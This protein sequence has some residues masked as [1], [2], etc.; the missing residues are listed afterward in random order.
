[1]ETKSR[2]FV[3]FDSSR[4]SGLQSCQAVGLLA[5]DRTY[6]DLLSLQR[7]VSDT[8]PPLDELELMARM[9]ERRVL[10]PRRNDKATNDDV[11]SPRR[12]MDDSGNGIRLMVCL[13]AQNWCWHVVAPQS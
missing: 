5:C 8:K 13:V 4:V 9:G 1:M 7:L 11:E 2:R 12:E 10:G 3:R 6:G